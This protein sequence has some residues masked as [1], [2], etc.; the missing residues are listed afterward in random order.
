MIT[1]NAIFLIVLYYSP[2]FNIKHFTY[3]IDPGTIDAFEFGI[4]I[5]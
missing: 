3:C 2:S 1:V 5:I 4:E